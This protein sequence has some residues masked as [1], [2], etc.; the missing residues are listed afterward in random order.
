[1]CGFLSQSV[2]HR[3]LREVM[4]L[5]LVEVIFFSKFFLKIASIAKL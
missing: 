3:Q 5:N 2:E 4:G 1:M